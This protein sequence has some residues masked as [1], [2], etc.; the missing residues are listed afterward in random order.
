LNQKLVE[1]T[2]N[3]TKVGQIIKGVRGMTSLALDKVVKMII[4]VSF[5]FADFSQIEELDINPAI[6]AQSQ[7]TIVD[8]KIK[9]AKPTHL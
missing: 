6:V 5:M 9:I 8:I 4:N 1:Q 2:L 3:H 7:V